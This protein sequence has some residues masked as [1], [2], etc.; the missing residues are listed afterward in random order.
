MEVWYENDHPPTTMYGLA[1]LPALV[2]ISMVLNRYKLP[3]LG[4]H[5]LLSIICTHH[6]ASLLYN[7]DIFSKRCR[8]Y[9]LL[10]LKIFYRL[11][12]SCDCVWNAVW[13][14]LTKPLRNV[15]CYQ[16]SPG[17]VDCGHDE[18][19]LSPCSIQVEKGTLWCE[20]V[21]GLVIF[22]SEQAIQVS[23]ADF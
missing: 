20:Y 7:T 19:Y 6:L 13:N 9:L 12:N 8:I 1:Q 4:L 14:H 18:S 5:P 3:W 10:I 15:S 11:F 22:W 16:K 2:E 17:I 21:T 23:W